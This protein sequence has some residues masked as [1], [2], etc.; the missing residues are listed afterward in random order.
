MRKNCLL[1]GVSLF[2][3]IIPLK[4]WAEDSIFFTSVNKECR[5]IEHD[6]NFSEQKCPAPNGWDVK[7]LDNGAL[8]WLIFTNAKNTLNTMNLLNDEGLMFGQISQGK[9]EWHTTDRKVSGIIFRVSGLMADNNNARTSRLLVFKVMEQGEFHYCG[10][11][12]SNEEARKH[13]RNCSQTHF[14]IE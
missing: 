3:N 6:E 10:W 4:A 7:V 14:L 12:K 2:L 5:L 13:L 11:S 9:I 1:I 8:V